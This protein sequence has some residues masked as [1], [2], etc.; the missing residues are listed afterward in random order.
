MSTILLAWNPLKF[1][2]GDLQDELDSVRR[3]EKASETWSVGASRIIQ[4]GDRFFMMRL[5]Q[6]PRGIVASGWITSRPF[7]APHWDPSKAQ[8]GEV[9]FYVDIVFTRLDAEPLVPWSRLQGAPF[10][11]FRWGIQ[12]SGVRIPPDI[13][14]AL[15]AE[16]QSA[17]TEDDHHGGELSDRSGYREGSLRR[18]YVNAYERNPAARALCVAH[19]GLRCSVCDVRLAEEYGPVASR[20]IHVHHL[21]PLSE[22]AAEYEV[23]PVR[24]LRP[25]C[26]NC[27]SVIHLRTPPYSIA[28]VKASMRQQ[29]RQ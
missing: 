24:D 15:E 17:T 19:H 20:L 28:E 27:H 8:E 22:I 2:W 3:G 23:D 4:P 12:R 16:W 10:S 1:P 11:Q 6:P 5:G 13:A 26:P 7:E 21:K 14:E 9:T 29:R 18:V 25:V